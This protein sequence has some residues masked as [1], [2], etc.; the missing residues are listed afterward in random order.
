MSLVS[1]PELERIPPI[2]K[3]PLYIQNG[4]MIQP[5]LECEDLRDIRYT[6]C[7]PEMMKSDFAAVCTFLANL[8]DIKLVRDARV[9]KNMW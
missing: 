6:G 5:I 4:I 9:D 2:S 7:K 8:E 1:L 3:N